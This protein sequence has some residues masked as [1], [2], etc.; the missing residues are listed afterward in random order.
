MA[1]EIAENGSEPSASPPGPF[2][3]PD[4]PGELREREGR[5]MDQTHNRP[6]TPWD[7]QCARVGCPLIGY[8]DLDTSWLLAIFDTDG[9]VLQALIRWWG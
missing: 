3:E 9:E 4:H 1:L 6:E 2:V 8:T 5:T 7:A